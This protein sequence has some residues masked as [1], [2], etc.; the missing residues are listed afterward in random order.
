MA[1]IA[2]FYGS[3]MGTTQ[4]AAEALKGLLGEDIPVYDVS[5]AKAQDF[6]QHDFLLLGSSTWGVGE[7][8]DDW[9][10]G[11]DELDKADL[12]GK[13]VALF[14]FGDQ[15]DHGETYANALG[16]LYDK[17]VEKGATVVGSWPTEGYEQTE[18]N[19]VRD[20]SFVGLALDDNNQADLTD[21]RIKKWVEQI[22][23]EGNL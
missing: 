12:S 6:E 11:I 3:T 13:K 17:A 5:S 22:K 20:G 16:I 10:S 23:K 9:V 21:E 18:S 1:Q 7:L 2:I 19:S 8:Q 15:E 14:G 4:E